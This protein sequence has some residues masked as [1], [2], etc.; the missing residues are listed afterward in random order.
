MI[1]TKTDSKHRTTFSDDA[2]NLSPN[3]RTLILTAMAQGLTEFTVPTPADDHNRTDWKVRTWLTMRDKKPVAF[4]VAYQSIR[5]EFEVLGPEIP[6][7]I[8]NEDT[9]GGNGKPNVLRELRELQKR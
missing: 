8:S 3:E 6:L 7:S 5:P 2:A 4:M 9:G 1:I